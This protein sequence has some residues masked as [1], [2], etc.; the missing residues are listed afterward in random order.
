MLIG[1]LYMWLQ[2]PC[3]TGVMDNI[4]G[5]IY[6]ATEEEVLLI[7]GVAVVE[8]FKMKLKLK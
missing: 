8:E 2:Y 3:F 1:S 5:E 4:V 6:L 7:N